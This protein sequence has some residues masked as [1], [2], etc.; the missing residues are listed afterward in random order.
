MSDSSMATSSSIP[1]TEWE[2]EF[3]GRLRFL[4]ENNHGALIYKDF[5]NRYVVKIEIIPLFL[6]RRHGLISREI[7][8]WVRMGVVGVCL[9]SSPHVWTIVVV[10]LVVVI[11]VMCPFL[12]PGTYFGHL[13]GPPLLPM[14]FPCGSLYI[15]GLPSSFSH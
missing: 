8:T 2:L 7:S 14:A 12:V 6:I 11:M 5:I 15:G 13:F 3:D 9:L 1:P 4:L 10:S